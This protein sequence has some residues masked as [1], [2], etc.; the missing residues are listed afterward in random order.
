ML[1]WNDAPPRPVVAFPWGCGGLF[2][3]EKTEEDLLTILIEIDR[4]KILEIDN[5]ERAIL[6]LLLLSLEYLF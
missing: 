4:I 1:G 6:L 5:L 2:W 3:F